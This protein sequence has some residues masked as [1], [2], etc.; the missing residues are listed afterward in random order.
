M[1]AT[2]SKRIARSARGVAVALSLGLESRGPCLLCGCGLD[3]LHRTVDAV[4]GRRA[5]GDSKADIARD[6]GLTYAQVAGIT[7]EDGGHSWHMVHSVPGGSMTPVQRERE[8]AERDAARAMVD[9]MVQAQHARGLRSAWPVLRAGLAIMD[10]I[11]G[12]RADMVRQEIANR[13]RALDPGRADRLSCG[14]AAT[15][16][17]GGRS[18]GGPRGRR[19]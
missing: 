10:G 4:R 17:P 18:D 7:G 6:L 8:R 5:A 2:R 9:R 15:A 3:A 12:Q 19:G 13:L 16:G 1:T 11:T 14:R